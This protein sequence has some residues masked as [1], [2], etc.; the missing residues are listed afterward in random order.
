ESWS[1]D[2]DSCIGNGPFKMDSYTVGEKMTLSKSETYYNADQIKLDTLEIRF[3]TDSSVEL[4]AYKNN[5]IQIAILPTADICAQ[6][7]DEAIFAPKLSCMWL[8]IN[9][10]DDVLKDVRVR[11]ALS[12]AI[13]RQSICEN[14]IG[15]GVT[16]AYSIVPE[17][18]VDLTNGKRFID[19]EEP[20]F[21]EDVAAAQQL[22]A[23][24]GYPGGE[25]FPEIIYGTSSNTDYE[26]TA[27]AIASWWKENLGITCNIQVED[28]STFIAH[29]KEK[30]H[31][32]VARYT[33][34]GS[35]SDPLAMLAYYKSTDSN[36]DSYFNN[37]EYDQ[38]LNDVRTVVDPKERF[39]IY[40]Q[41]DRI[42]MENMAVIP[43]YYPTAKYLSKS[44]IEGIYVT[45][46]GC[47]EFKSAYVTE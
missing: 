4:M 7:P 35:Y 46:I 8:I 22:L 33:I 24:A 47:L 32:D 21:K 3:I 39:A 6:Y 5:D 15:G 40:H 16:P 44:N 18:S 28:S 43:L 26:N 9:T 30:G 38:L 10:Q 45:P 23:D 34:G 27:Q 14:I 29:R 42:L 31:F 12:M 13:D 2:P 37:A 25:G 17:A 41:L 36:N 20:Y 11:Q 19:V 1:L